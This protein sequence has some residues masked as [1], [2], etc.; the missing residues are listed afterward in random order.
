[1]SRDLSWDFSG[2]LRGRRQINFF[3]FFARVTL[4]MIVNSSQRGC[5]VPPVLT[6]PDR[7]QV[8][9][10]FTTVGRSHLGILT[11]SFHK[12]AVLSL[13]VNSLQMAPIAFIMETVSSCCPGRGNIFMNYDSLPSHPRRVSRPPVVKRKW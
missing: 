4:Q 3:F 5:G 7:L 12:G 1:M 2:L 9:E 8:A 6:L 11:H 10:V 13:S